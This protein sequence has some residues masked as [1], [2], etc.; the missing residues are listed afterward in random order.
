[1]GLFDDLG[2]ALGGGGL[3]G[4]QGGGAQGALLQAAAGML[5]Q[6]GLETLVKS[7]QQKGLGDVIGSWVSTGANAPVSA[8]QLTHALGPDLLGKLAG[9][10]GL[11]PAAVASQLT[12]V[13]PGLVD[14]LTPGGQ[15]PAANA[16]Q[17]QLGGLL[18]GL[19]S[20]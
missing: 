13:L 3:G 7:F 15:L 8:D 2:K 4:L 17:D 5:A 16:L 18:K 14:H 9:Q 10:T 6:G 1:M 12:K 19:F 11:D 20:K